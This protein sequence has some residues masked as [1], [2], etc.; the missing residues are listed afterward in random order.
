[1]DGAAELRPALRGHDSNR[2][3]AEDA[4]PETAERL[5][6]AITEAIGPAPERLIDSTPRNALRVP[7]LDAV[8]PDASFVYVY[9]EP[10]DTLSSMAEAWES[11]DYATYRGC[12][13]GPARP[14]PYC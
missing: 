5:R 12:P 4:S 8:F 6:A 1:M 3:T 10:R 14:G 11:G 7:Y 2:R 9:R 13:T